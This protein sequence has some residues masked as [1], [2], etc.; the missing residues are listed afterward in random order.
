[1]SWPLQ[2]WQRLDGISR[3]VSI[4]TSLINADLWSSDRAMHQEPDDALAVMFT[5]SPAQMA[6]P[7]R[8]H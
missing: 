7:Q 8:L 4:G 5:L 6:L 3:F 1:M 2:C